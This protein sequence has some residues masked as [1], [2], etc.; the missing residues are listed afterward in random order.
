[1]KETTSRD[2]FSGNTLNFYKI[3]L[4]KISES[5]LLFAKFE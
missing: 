4:K 3:F 5:K 1:M 2:N